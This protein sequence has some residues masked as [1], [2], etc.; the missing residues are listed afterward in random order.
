MTKQHKEGLVA[1]IYL[2]PSFILI[3]SFQLLPMLMSAYFSLTDFNLL[4]APEW[5]G[6]KNYVKVASDPYIFE[7]VKNTLVYTFFTV[8]IQ[9]LLAMLFGAF[10]AAKLRNKFGGFLRSVMFIPVIASAVSAGTIWRLILA[11]DGGILNNVLNFFHMNSVNWLGSKSTALFSV[12]IVAI[13]KSVGYFLVIYYAGI[14]N[15]PAVLYEVAKVDGATAWQQFKYITV[16]LLKPITYFVVTLGMIWSF[17][18]FD[19]VYVMTGGGPGR[20][21]TTLVMSIYNAAF[22]DYRIG[23]A[24]A[25]AVLMLFVILAV[26]F[27]QRHFFTE[28]EV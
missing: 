10:L 25:I 1:W 28:K 14:M 20:S 3:I 6:F 16:P 21:T 11:T 5:V 4:K 9:T 13:W 2:L 17:Q 26:N 24:S 8:P 19:M 18:V 23:Y 12:G 27:L 7:S 22:K 15:I